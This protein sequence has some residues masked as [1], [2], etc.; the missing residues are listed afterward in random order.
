M[1]YIINCVD[2]GYEHAHFLH[3]AFHTTSLDVITHIDRAK[4]LEKHTGGK[5]AQQT[6]PCCADGD[7]STGEEGGE[8]G[9]LH[10]EE[11][12]DRHRQHHAQQGADQAEQEGNQSGIELGH[13]EAA[14]Q[15][16]HGE[17]DQPAANNPEKDCADNLE[18]KRNNDGSDH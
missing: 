10:A 6:T 4:Q 1:A 7:T 17:A 12:E 8:A 11:A 14:P 13:R 5:I 15:H 9:G 16:A 18:Q 2:G 3:G